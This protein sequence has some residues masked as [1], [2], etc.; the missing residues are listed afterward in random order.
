MQNLFCFCKYIEKNGV[1][2]ILD[3]R[4]RLCLSSSDSFDS[5]LYINY[6][7]KLDT[8]NVNR[9]NEVDYKC[10]ESNKEKN[11]KSSKIMLLSL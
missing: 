5:P 4:A 3:L 6:Y 10:F 7:E 2:Y 11:C 9:K 1:L 8:F